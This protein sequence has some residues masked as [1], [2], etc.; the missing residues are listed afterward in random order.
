M[1][2]SEGGGDLE[3]RSPLLCTW[4]PS[5]KAML[6]DFSRNAAYHNQLQ[7]GQ[8]RA[9]SFCMGENTSLNFDNV[10]IQSETKGN[11]YEGRSR[12]ASFGSKIV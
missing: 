2:L 9:Q 11:T 8:K 4:L 6:G 10:I 1:G 3:Q 7:S 5:R 12:I